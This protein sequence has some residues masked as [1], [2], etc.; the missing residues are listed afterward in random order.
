MTQVRAVLTLLLGCADPQ[1]VHIGELGSF[2]IA[3]GKA[4]A[5]GCDVALQDLSQSGLVERDIAGRQ[6]GDLTGIDVDAEHLVAQLGHACGM[7]GSEVPGSEYGA[8]HTAYI[9][10]QG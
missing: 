10:R 2:G 1:E 3:R 9:G 7:G 8:S 5:C 6:F 4:Q